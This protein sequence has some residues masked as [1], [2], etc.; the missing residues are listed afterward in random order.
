[1]SQSEKGMLSW[2]HQSIP[3]HNFLWPRV[4]IVFKIPNQ[5]NIQVEGGEY[6]AQDG[7]E[8]GYTPQVVGSDEKWVKRK[9][10]KGKTEMEDKGHHPSGSVQVEVGEEPREE[11]DV[12]EPLDTQDLPLVL[13]NS[14][15]M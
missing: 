2:D 6:G 14:F 13:E 8:S 10:K 3:S 5:R 7:E 4:S 1:M 9:K 15:V 12:E 11:P